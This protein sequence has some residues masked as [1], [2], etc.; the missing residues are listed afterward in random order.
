[1]EKVVKEVIYSSGFY[2]DLKSIYLYGHETFGEIMSEILQEQ[3]MH[4]TQGLSF[5][6]HQYPECKHL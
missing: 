4:R 1:M 5:R 6:F 3:I 2:E